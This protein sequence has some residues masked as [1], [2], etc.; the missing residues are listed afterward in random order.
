MQLPD[1]DFRGDYQMQHPWILELLLQ[2]PSMQVAARTAHP[3]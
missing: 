3:D 1:S 2:S